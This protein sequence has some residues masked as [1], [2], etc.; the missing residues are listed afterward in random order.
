MFSHH[1]KLVVRGEPTAKTGGAPAGE[2]GEIPIGPAAIKRMQIQVERL[3][4]S[5]HEVR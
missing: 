1:H 2:V 5:D 4:K 3:L